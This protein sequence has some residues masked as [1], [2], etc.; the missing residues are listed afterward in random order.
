MLNSSAPAEWV[1][2]RAAPRKSAGLW[3]R[4]SNT[5]GTNSGNGA[6]T[7]SASTTP[8]RLESWPVTFCTTVA[9]GPGRPSSCP[10]SRPGWRGRD[11]YRPLIDAWEI[12]NRNH[13][14]SPVGFEGLPYIAGS[15]FH[16][17]AHI[18]SWKT[19]LFCEKD[20]QAVKAAIRRNQGVGLV[21]D[22]GPRPQT[23]LPATVQT[24]TVLRNFRRPSL[25]NR[26]TAFR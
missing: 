26:L 2:S 1:P 16:Q 14:F 11:E 15:D 12:A 13:I 19:L 22:E 6:E 4:R 5:V 20:A 17:P 10:R 8:T 7:S 18:R 21:F 25:R 9:A 24:S 3:F 23:T